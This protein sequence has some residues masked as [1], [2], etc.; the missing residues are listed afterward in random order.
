[1]KNLGPALWRQKKVNLGPVYLFF[2][3]TLLKDKWGATQG[4]RRRLIAQAKKK[5]KKI[6]RAQES[7]FDLISSQTY[8]GIESSSRRTAET[9]FLVERW[10]LHCKDN[11]YWVVGA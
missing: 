3:A 2:Y 5:K 10:D 6:Q 4:G 9:A 1:M 8:N 7:V 11:Y